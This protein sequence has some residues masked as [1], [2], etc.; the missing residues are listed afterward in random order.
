MPVAV[1]ADDA[2][3]LRIERAEDHRLRGTAELLS[4]RR[5]RR[6]NVVARR[7]G[8]RERCVEQ[9][10]APD[11]DVRVGVVACERTDARRAQNSTSLAGRT[12]TGLSG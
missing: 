5:R 12:C 2:D 1:Q 10:L 11:G 8:E 4:Y 6:G 9:R 7:R 3:E